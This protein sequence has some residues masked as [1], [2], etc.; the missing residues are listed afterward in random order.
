[1]EYYLGLKRMKCGMHAAPWMNFEN[2]MLKRSQTHRQHLETETRL[3][4]GRDWS[5]GRLEIKA[6]AD[7]RTGVWG[8]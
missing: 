1:M 7:F 3:V 5:W 6:P 8:S 4:A 2:I